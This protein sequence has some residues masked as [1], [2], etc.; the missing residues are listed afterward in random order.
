MNIIHFFG[1][2]GFMLTGMKEGDLLTLHSFTMVIRGYQS[3]CATCFSIYRIAGNSDGM[4][5]S[6]FNPT[7]GMYVTYPLA[8]HHNLG[9]WCVHHR[10]A[11]S[12]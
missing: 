6:S 10:D 2:G 8:K 4:I 5:D 3:P 7:R 1:G 11:S 9:C 12:G